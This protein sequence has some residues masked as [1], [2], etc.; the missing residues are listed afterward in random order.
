MLLFFYGVQLLGSR[1]ELG[2][3][4]MT[5]QGCISELAFAWCQDSWLFFL[6][7]LSLKSLFWEENEVIRFIQ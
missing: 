5:I 1:H 4:K 3:K 2:R 7:E 6:V